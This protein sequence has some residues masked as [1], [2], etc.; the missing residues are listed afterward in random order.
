MLRFGLT[1]FIRDVLPFGF[2]TVAVFLVV[3]LLLKP[4][5]NIYLLLILKILL[6]AL[7]Y[8]GVMKLLRV[9]IL[10]EI[11]GYFSGMK[12]KFAVQKKN[13]ETK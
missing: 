1:D 3:S 9:V 2:I 11:L 10:E 4:V 6:S 7:L 12:R 8:V 5:D 13:D